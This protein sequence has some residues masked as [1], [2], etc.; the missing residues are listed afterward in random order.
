MAT[1]EELRAAYEA[2]QAQI[3][4]NAE[5]RAKAQQEHAARM[6][7]VERLAAE[8]ATRRAAEGT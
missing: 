6:A 2:Q 7:E 5:L 1:D 8:A 4:R 3:A